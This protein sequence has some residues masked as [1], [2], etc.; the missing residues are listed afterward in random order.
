MLKKILIGLGVL[1]VLVAGAGGIFVAVSTSAYEASVAKKY[2]VPLPVIA[3]STDPA[4]LARGKHLNSSL[5]GCHNCHGENLAGGKLEQLGPIGTAIYP[6]IT[7]GKNGALAQYTDG[8]LARLIRHGIK[9]DGTTVRFMPSGDYQWW[10][11]EDLTALISYLRTVPAVD[12]GAYVSEFT[13]FAKVLD[14][15]DMFTLDIAR[16]ID[17]DKKWPAP[18][19]APTVEYGASI[20]MLCSGCHGPG[21][22][23]G[24]IPGA[25]PDFPVPQNLTPHETGLSAWTYED[26]DKLMKTGI[27]KNGQKCAEMMP[28][29]ITRNFD[30][31]ELKALWAYLRSVPPK[32]FGGR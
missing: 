1:I 16:R 5:G 23:G 18:V 24:P 12:S 30:E 13:T 27:R 19:V 14:R 7:A 26:F 17:H 3:L 10:P 28:I 15:L 2:D 21:L 11:I 20:A 25:P 6:N 4:V 29:D 9:K 31:T 32:P 8:E 22:T